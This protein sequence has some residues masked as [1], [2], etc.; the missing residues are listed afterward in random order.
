MTDAAYDYDLFVIGG[1]SGGVRAGRIAAQAGAK[2]GLAEE[3]R[4]GGTCVVR[5][6]VPKKFMVY[7]SKYGKD[8]ELSAGYG[9]SVGEVSYDH[10]KFMVGLHAEVDRLSAI[11][12][13]NLKN[14][15]VDVFDDRA[16]FVDQHTLRLKSSGKT[17]TAKKILI[18]VGGRPWLPSAEELPG[19]E[20]V[21]D[22]N[23]VFELTE[24]PKRMVIAGGGYIAVEFAHVFA[25][26]GTE[27]CLVYRGDTVLRGFDDEIR[28]AVHEGLK[29]DGV[30]VV[31]KCV[32]KSIEKT[33]AGLKVTL[34]SGTEIETDVVL[35]AVG[36]RANTEGLGCDK[37][38]VKLAENGD[39]IVDEW[40]RTSA[41]NI[42]AVGDVTGRVALTPVAIREGHAFADTEFG[43]KPWKMDHEN[44]PT[45]V[46]T[47]P[48]VGTVGISEAEARKT[49]GEIDIYKT[50]FRPM[51]NM[52]NGDQTRTFMKLV[53][54]AS[55]QRVLGVH[56]VGD[57]A[58]EMIQ[59]AAIAVKM[60]ATKQDFDRTCALHPSAAEELV[61]MRTKWVPEGV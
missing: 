58:A 53:V 57:D 1:G 28:L 4:M 46:F 6:C 5:G 59:T 16:E 61:T 44:I 24:L 20:H 23:G 47:Q 7:S 25:G 51:K 13:R 50:K 39:V 60:G 56:V 12:D 3:Y 37:A 31:T 8:I 10:G 18:A 36:R 32:F 42:W 29:E 30:R 26:L 27:V 14:A 45:A 9:W 2:V 17:I 40:S 43:G 21:I 48:E 41:E 54:R 34:S 19:V 55:D 15:G 38:G 22:S 49:Y 52:L 35:M 11:Y 33:D